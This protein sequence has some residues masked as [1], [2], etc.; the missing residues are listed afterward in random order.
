MTRQFAFPAL[1]ATAFVALA[2]P[3]Y[4]ADDASRAWIAQLQGTVESPAQ[5]SAVTAKGDPAD[6]FIA[7]LLNRSSTPALVV[8]TVAKGD[9]AQEFIARLSFART[10]NGSAVEPIGPELAS[11]QATT[12]VAN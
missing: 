7:N 8:S 12:D 10:P 9:P 4:A 5:A 11:R 1:V 3:A 2:A 6:D